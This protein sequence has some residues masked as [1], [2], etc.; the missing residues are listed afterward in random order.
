MPT[1]TGAQPDGAIRIAIIGHGKIARDQH[2]PAILDNPAYALAAIVDPH[3]PGIAGLPV[4]GT[5][6]D[7]LAAMG[8]RIDAVALCT[9]PAARYPI[10]CAALAAGLHVLLEKPPAATLGEVAALDGQA[11]D[12]GRALYAAWHAQHA[13]AV[14]PAK[15][16]LA[17]KVIARLAIE[18]R[19]DVHKW[20]MGQDWIWAPS[21][22]G[23]FDPGINALSIATAILPMPLL[24][25]GARLGIPVGRQTPISAALDFHGGDFTAVFDWRHGEIE[26]WTIEIDTSDGHNIMLLDGG[27][28]LVVDGE[29]LS[30]QTIGEYRS[31]YTR[32]AALIAANRSKIDTEPLRIVADANLLAHREPV[33]FEAAPR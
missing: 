2:I 29:R 3:S 12:A 13:A 16:L 31:I 4:F 11:R 5:V 32:F 10:A 33:E 19:E 22:F 6:A 1:R 20:H 27:A 17:D 7:M 14:A 26:C 25:A 30:L 23:V 18:W 15:A 28:A 8:D 21:G 24:V 9:P